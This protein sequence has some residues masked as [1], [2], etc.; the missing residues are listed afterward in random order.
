MATPTLHETDRVWPSI[1]MGLRMEAISR[2]L[3]AASSSCKS[4]TWRMMMTNSSPPRPADGV[5]V[6]HGLDQAAGH[7]AQQAIA[8]VVARCR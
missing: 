6:A 1:C 8:N 2:S 3:M 4:V 7:L 5:G